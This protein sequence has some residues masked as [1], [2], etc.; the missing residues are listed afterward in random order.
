MIGLNRLEGLPL[1]GLLLGLLFSIC[2]TRSLQKNLKCKQCW[3]L[4]GRF[5]PKDPG[6]YN[7]KPRFYHWANE[8]SYQHSVLVEYYICRPQGSLQEFWAFGGRTSK[9]RKFG[10]LNF[11]R[12]ADKCE[13]SLGIES[14]AKYHATA[15][16]NEKPFTVDVLP[17]RGFEPPTF[18][19][20]KQAGRLSSLPTTPQC[21]NAT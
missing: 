13:P 19:F 18:R 5:D 4:R 14:L 20:T 15:G 8:A 21:H 9:S 1:P 10:I 7:D 2:N 17:R 3:K 12:S 11:E 6:C 16:W